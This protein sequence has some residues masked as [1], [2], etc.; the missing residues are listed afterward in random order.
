MGVWAGEGLGGSEAP[1]LGR[2]PKSQATCVCAA[3]RLARI[4]MLSLRSIPEW[5]DRFGG[6]STLGSVAALRMTSFDIPSAGGKVRG[7]G[8]KRRDRQEG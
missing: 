5:V 1:Y 8:A 7:A 6:E 4:V 3:A 2:M